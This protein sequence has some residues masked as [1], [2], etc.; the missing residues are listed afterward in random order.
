MKRVLREH[1][2][3]STQR[4]LLGNVFPALRGVGLDWNEI[5]I[6]VTCYVDGPISVKDRESLEDMLTQILADVEP[7]VRIQL[8]IQDLPAPQKLG[9]HLAWAY[10]RRESPSLAFDSQSPVASRDGAQ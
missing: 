4:A 6:N 9:Q 1:V 3:L 8:Q 5:S 7:E 2:L 10:L